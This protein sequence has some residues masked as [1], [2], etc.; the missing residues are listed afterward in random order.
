MIEHM[1]LTL[2]FIGKVLIGLSV[3]LVHHRIWQDKKIDKS[4]LKEMKKE[5]SIAVVG[6][7]SLAVGYIL[8]LSL[9]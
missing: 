2:D 7:I 5:Y 6:I 3:L 1:A 4:V 8:H 9:L